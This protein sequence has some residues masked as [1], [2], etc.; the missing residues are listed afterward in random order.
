MIAK[1]GAGT[2]VADWVEQYDLQRALS[3]AGVRQYRYA[4]KSLDRWAGRAVGLQELDADLFN[5]WLR[6]LQEEGSRLAPATV[7]CRRRHLLA[8][9]R[10]AADERKAEEPPRRLRP[11]RVP[12]EP[13]RAWTCDEVRAILAVCEGLRRTKAGAFPRAE[14]W[15]LAVRIA[16]DTGL[17]LT[18]LLRIRAADIQPG[19]KIV[20][21]QSKTN[22]GVVCQLAPST[23]EAL[24]QSLRTHPR[25]LAIPWASSRETFR[26]QFAL[27]VRRAGVREGT[28]KWIRRSSATDVELHFPGAGAAHLGHSHGSEIAMR[29]YLDQVILQTTRPT[30]TPIE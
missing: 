12:W 14:W 10:A 2:T 3:P 26:R 11:A 17:R 27:M 15:S 30:P 18:D 28:W 6:S 22:R 29:H 1:A 9:W 7:A 16:W 19:G 25:R 21:A 13:P 4:A 20:L 24:R 23:M 8:L 5:R